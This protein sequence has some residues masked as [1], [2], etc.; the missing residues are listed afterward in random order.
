MTRRNSRIEMP[1]G[2]SR[3]RFLGLT[4]AAAG[5]VVLSACGANAVTTTTAAATTTA[6][7]AAATTTAGLTIPTTTISSLTVGYN[8]PNRLL[9]APLFIGQSQG[10][11]EEV[12]ITELEVN[13]ADDPLP[14]TIAGSY[15]IALFDSDVLYA[16]EDRATSLGEPLGLKMLN[17]NL[18]S[19][20]MILLSAAGI[21]N[22]DDL[23][24]KRVSGGRP[25]LVNEAV[26]K[27]MLSELG[28]DWE[29]DVIFTE[30]TGGSNDWIQALLTGQVDASI[31]FSRHIPLVEGEGGNV[32]YQEF[33]PS[34]QGGFGML[35]SKI[36]EDPGFPAAW[37]YAYIQAQRFVK[38]VDNRDEVARI[39]NEDHGIDLPPAFATV[40]ELDAQVLS[41]DL[42]FD[43]VEM[44]D[45][46]AFVAPFAEVPAD[47]AWRDYTDVSG[48]HVAQAAL[49][50]PTNPS[51]DLS[52]G[53]ELIANF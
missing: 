41:Q 14:P 32:L 22:A 10:F 5:G 45:W 38:T 25:G 9:R 3:R 21:E 47:V 8:N 27:F 33:R 16:A 50:L 28:L 13:D 17:I 44:D 43:P 2:V 15:H 26:A 51:A 52:T 34:P 12:G 4:A 19:Q 18:G 53:E 30:M 35:Q 24:G 31:G 48:L 29:T 7:G 40:Y 1:T 39:L 37:A 49:G 20:P 36:D 42:G 23:R 46:L 11:F 6:G